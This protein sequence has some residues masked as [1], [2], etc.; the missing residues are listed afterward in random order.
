M[1]SGTFFKTVPRPVACLH[2]QWHVFPVRCQLPCSGKFDCLVSHPSLANHTGASVEVAKA[3]CHKCSS[4][5][6]LSFGPFDLYKGGCARLICL[7][8]LVSSCHRLKLLRNRDCAYK[9]VKLQS[10]RYPPVFP[11][12][13]TFVLRKL[14]FSD[15]WFNISSP[16]VQCGHYAG[17]M[18]W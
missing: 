14:C 15:C 8:Q 11:T 4:K 12:C 1:A 13:S 3:T 16:M 10:C 17:T 5:L 9:K 18:Q 6:C 2:G 7:G